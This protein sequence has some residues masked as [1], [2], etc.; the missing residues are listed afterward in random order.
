MNLLKVPYKLI[1]INLLRNEQRGKE[2]MQ[3][4][5]LATV[6][7]IR[8][9]DGTVI[10][11]SL[12]IMDFLDRESRLLPQNRKERARCMQIVQ[13]ICAEIQP[14]QNLS[15]VGRVKELAGEQAGLEWAKH[16]NLSKLKIINDSLVSR[17]EE[18][19]VGDKVSLAD[20][21]LVPQLYSAN[22]FGID[23]KSELPNLY[24]IAKRLEV[25]EEFQR[26]HPHAQPDCPEDI[27]KLGLLFA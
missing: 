6:P 12:A 24:E 7:A 20:V 27:K 3:I 13:T 2:Y 5:P 4:N 9:L 17:G 26:S 21:C 8:T 15:V 18:L 1:P 22:R 19:C 23:I 16:H 25:L 11:Q 14:L 10:W